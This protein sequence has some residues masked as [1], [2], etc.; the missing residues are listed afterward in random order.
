MKKYSFRSEGRKYTFKSKLDAES[1]RKYLLLKEKNVSET[2]IEY[3][4][5][6]FKNK[7]VEK[8][9]KKKKLPISKTFGSRFGF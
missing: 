8:P 5:S 9:L 1:K 6:K 4:K 2:K 3:P 7:L